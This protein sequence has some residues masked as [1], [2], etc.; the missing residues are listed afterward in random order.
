MR[1]LFGMWNNTRMVVLTAMCA[2]LYAAVLIPFMVVPLIPGLTHFR[3][4]E[5]VMKLWPRPILVVHGLRDAIIP[6]DRGERLFR[7]AIQPKDHI[8]LPEMDHNQII[9]DDDTARAVR[10]FFDH[11][12]P[13][14]V[15]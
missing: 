1:E 12:R 4:A 10:D 11:A 5:L 6:S 13:L 15:I 9:N 7:E 2:S 14:P 8:W 3:P